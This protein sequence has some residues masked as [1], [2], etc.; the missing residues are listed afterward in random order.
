MISQKSAGAHESV[1][2]PRSAPVGPN[3]HY[4]RLAV[5]QLDPA[6]LA[7][8]WG[9]MM[10]RKHVHRYSDIARIWIVMECRRTGAKAAVKRAEQLGISSETRRQ[11]FGP[12]LAEWLARMRRIEKFDTPAAPTVACSMATKLSVEDMDWIESLFLAE[13]PKN[14]V[15]R[16][17][18]DRLR[19]FAANT[20]GR[21]HLESV[22]Y[23]TVWRLCRRLKDCVVTEGMRIPDRVKRV[24]KKP[25]RRQTKAEETDSLLIGAPSAR[26][27]DSNV[28]F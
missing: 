24:R 10:K 15:Y 7:R 6:E 21:K 13:P 3:R 20:P 11:W 18:T 2:Q 16:Q 25:T 1:E 12:S 5:A 22:G 26:A 14:R 9:A 8:L 23:S 19:T 17:F 28:P 4:M 27:G